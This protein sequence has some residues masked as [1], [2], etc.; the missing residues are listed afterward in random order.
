MP[1][2]GR[3]QYLFFLLRLP[4]QQITLFVWAVRSTELQTVL[5]VV[6]CQPFHRAI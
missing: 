5:P 3:H 4:Q 2:L 6:T 1:L